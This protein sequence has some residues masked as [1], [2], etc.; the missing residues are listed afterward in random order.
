MNVYK[1]IRKLFL[2]ERASSEDYIC[3]LKSRGV[4]IGED[5]VIFRPFN[6]VIDAQNPHLLSI[7]NHVMMTGPVTILTHDYSWSVLKKKYGVILG[8]QRKTVIGNNVFIGWGAMVLG[9][10]VIGD[11]V[12]IGAGSV[13]SGV[14]ESDSVYAGNPAKKMMPLE[15]FLN[16]RQKRQLDEAYTYVLE[17]KKRYGTYP[18]EDKLDEYFYLFSDGYNLNPHFKKKMLLLMNEE[19]CYSTIR[20]MEKQFSD[21]AD[22]LEYVNQRAEEENK[23]GM[24][25]KH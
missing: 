11:N 15:E 21:Y 19:F 20:G 10:S 5:V 23:L 6:T 7:G 1:M 17:Y 9:G 18:T 8:N 22:F 16:K 25:G 2:K 3:F 4:L 14:I 24:A 12:I 13:V